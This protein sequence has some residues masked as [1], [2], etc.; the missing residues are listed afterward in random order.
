[1]VRE[2]VVRFR[3]ATK[4]VYGEERWRILRNLR[5]NAREIMKKL[6]VKSYVHGSVAR[7][8]VTRKS[9]IDIII[10]EVIPS[11]LVESYVEY[12]YR[13]IVQ[14]TPNSAIKVFYELSPNISIVF[15]LIPLNQREIEFYDFGGKS[16]LYGD[17]R[18][19]GINKK[20]LFIEPTDGGHVEWSVIGR[21]YEA[22]KKLGIGVETVEERVR[23]LTKR[24]KIGRT[25]IYM[26]EFVPP[27]KGVEEYLKN[28]ADRDPIVRRMVRER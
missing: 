10:L 13:Y 24:D 2:K 27:Q 4:V 17:E 16:D 19:M 3:D 12:E 7:G 1:V 15:P 5:E 11:Y 28:L 20:L 21:E 25:G 9:D 8:D 26:K 14:A 23:V 6:P 18:V 22:A